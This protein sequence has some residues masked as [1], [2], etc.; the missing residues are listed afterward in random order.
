MEILTILKDISLALKEI[1]SLGIY[2][3]DL[4]PENIVMVNG[5]YKLCDFGSA[6][7]KMIDYD[8]LNKKEKN[9]INDYL[10]SNSTLMYRS[11]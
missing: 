9:S 2:H 10:E 6:I 7:T 8:S 11:P 3:L 5:S 1:H 4:K